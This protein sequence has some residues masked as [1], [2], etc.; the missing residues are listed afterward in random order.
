MYKYL[1]TPKGNH[2]NFSK[3]KKNIILIL[4]NQMFCDRL[5][6]EQFWLIQNQVRSSIKGC[7][8]TTKLYKKFKKV[9]FKSIYINYSNRECTVLKSRTFSVVNHWVLRGQ[10][11]SSRIFWNFFMITFGPF[12]FSLVNKKTLV[13]FRILSCVNCGQFW[14]FGTLSGVNCG[15]FWYFEYI[16]RRWLQTSFAGKNYKACPGLEPMNTALLLITLPTAK[17]VYKRRNNVQY[18]RRETGDMWQETWDRKH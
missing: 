18:R 11:D 14:Y 13:I 6:D 10:C 4:P 9:F 2:K 5:F 12:F 16:F 15:K 1:L 7:K 3:I 8:K 17:F